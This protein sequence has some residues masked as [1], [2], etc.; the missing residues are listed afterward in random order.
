MRDGSIKVLDFGVAKLIAVAVDDRSIRRS[1]RIG[2]RSAAIRERRSTWRRSSWRGRPADVAKRSVQRRRDSVSDGHRP[3]AVSRNDGGDARARDERRPRTG[4]A[5]DQPAGAAGVERRD[6]QGAEAHARSSLSVR[7][8]A[9]CRARGDVGH[10]FVDAHG[11][12][13]RRRR[14][15]DRRLRS[16]TPVDSG[17][18]RG[19]PA[20]DRPRGALAPDDRFSP[21]ACCACWRDAGPPRGR[22]PAAR[23]SQR[24]CVEG[25]PRDGCRGHAD[26]GVVEDAGTDR[27][28][29]KR[30][31]GSRAVAS[32]TSGR[33]RAISTWRSSSMAAS[34]RRAIACASRF[35]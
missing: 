30:G 18:D 34:S 14:D 29:S 8:R 26:D 3:A 28:V 35:A 32:T 27:A 20:P 5:R 21:V 23:Q 12:C 9:R 15:R 16:A 25:V 6:R 4:G 22:R 1:T 10:V 17:S 13:A 31:A 24:R 19:G 33:S 7:A 2:T 11:R